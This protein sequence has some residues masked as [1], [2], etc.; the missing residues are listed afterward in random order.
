M[1]A[2]DFMKDLPRKHRR[3]PSAALSAAVAMRSEVAPLYA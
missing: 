2:H 3:L 1:S